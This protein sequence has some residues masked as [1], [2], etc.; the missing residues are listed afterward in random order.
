MAEELSIVEDRLI[1]TAVV[2][3]RF[4]RTKETIFTC[5]YIVKR[6]QRHFFVCDEGTVQL[7]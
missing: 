7:Y 3:E 5:I 4:M 6:F 1:R 2:R